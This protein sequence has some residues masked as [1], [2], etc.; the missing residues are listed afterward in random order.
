M[1]IKHQF[2]YLEQ[3]DKMYRHIEARRVPTLATIKWEIEW[4]S[5]SGL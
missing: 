2:D 3:I 4:S 1:V 5:L